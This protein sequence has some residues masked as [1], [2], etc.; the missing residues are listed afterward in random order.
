MR[1]SRSADN[2]TSSG[3][4]AGSGAAASGKKK[5]QNQRPPKRGAADGNRKQALWKHGLTLS[6][7]SIQSKIGPVQQCAIAKN[8]FRTSPATTSRLG[9]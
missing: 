7:E 2:P 9:L 8:T 6:Q 3:F 5:R 4:A 1:C